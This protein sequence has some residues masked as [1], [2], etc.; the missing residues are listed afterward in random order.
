[1]MIPLTLVLIFLIILF[2]YKVE[3]FI[4]KGEDIPEDIKYKYTLFRKNKIRFNFVKDYL[5]NADVHD[6]S[7][8]IY[9]YKTPKTDKYYSSNVEDLYEIYNTKDIYYDKIVDVIDVS[10]HSY[11]LNLFDEN[12]KIDISFCNLKNDLPDKCSLLTCNIDENTHDIM[13]RDIFYTE[14]DKVKNDAKNSLINTR[15]E[16]KEK[17]DND[18]VIL[19]SYLDQ[20]NN[21]LN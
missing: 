16:N 18:E 10:N 9:S 13:L 20:R 14:Y 15:L 3:P 4:L 2:Y 17:Y 11:V 8:C 19:I 5:P 7:E 12:K 21:I 6:D 1:M